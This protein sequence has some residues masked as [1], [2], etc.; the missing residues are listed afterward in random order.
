VEGGVCDPEFGEWDVGFRVEGWRLRVKGL[1]F[2][3]YGLG[4]GFRFWG[5]EFGFQFSG[6]RALVCRAEQ[7][8]FR[9]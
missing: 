3:V 2:G 8:G 9:T 6:I 5:L 1:G 7:L 4:F